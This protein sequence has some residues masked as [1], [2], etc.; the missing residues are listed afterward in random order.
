MFFNFIADEYR[1]PGSFDT[2]DPNTT[3]IYLGN[4][5]PKMSEQQ[6]CQIFGKYGPLASVKIM[7]PRT[8]DERSRNRNCGFVAFM[9]RKDGERALKALSG[10]EIM[11]YEMKLGWGKAVPIPPHPIYIPPA[12]ME[13]TM[14][15]PQ[16][17][18]P[19]NAQPN[20]NLKIPREQWNDKENF[21]K[22]LQNAVVKVVI[23]T[24]R[25]LLSL[26]HRMIEFVVR[27]GPMFEAMIMNREISNPTF[28]FL[29][30]NQSPAHVYY[31]WRLFSILQVNHFLYH[32][33]YYHC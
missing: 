8:D 10:K 27:E 17:G 4:I 6:L 25:M 30:D 24:D 32:C 22:V 28:R 23:P 21:E 12:L 31:R 3:N 2:G 20:P 5:N 18:L 14:P 15:P 16:S 13:L 9:N 29:F 26:I 33:Y 11:N 19:F 7:W 1:L